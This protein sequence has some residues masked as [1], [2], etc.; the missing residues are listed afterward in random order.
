MKTQLPSNIFNEETKT[1]LIGLLS[2]LVTLWAILD[3]IPSFFASLFNTILGNLILLIIVVLV[4]AKDMKYGIL[5]AIIF[6]ILYR[7][8]SLS[9]K[10]AFSWSQGSIKEFIQLQNSINPKIIFD[11]RETQKQA[12]QEEVDY[13]LENKKWPWSQETQDSYEESLQTNPYVRLYPPDAISDVRTKYNENAIL[14]LLS[15][16]KKDIEI[17]LSQDNERKKLFSNDRDGLGSYSFR[18]GLL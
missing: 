1:I 15:S 3:I 10:E 18:S 17:Q 7:F 2:I 4:V 8:H 14:D 6:I 13:F 5:M 11:T 9:T 16:Q 12:S